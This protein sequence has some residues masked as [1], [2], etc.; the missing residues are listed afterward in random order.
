GEVV[1]GGALVRDRRDRLGDVEA[2]DRRAFLR[3]LH[4]V[5][6]AL[7]AGHSRNQHDLAVEPSHY[8]QFPSLAAYGGLGGGFAQVAGRATARPGGTG[9]LASCRRSSSP[10]PVGWTA[11]KTL[12][13]VEL[14]VGDTPATLGTHDDVGI[15]AGADDFQYTAGYRDD[16]HVS[17]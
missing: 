9:G 5:R 10:Y 11:S 3:E 7:A 8:D 14:L 4:C 17:P 12:V 16:G 1:R 2:G 13:Q 15:D 6:P